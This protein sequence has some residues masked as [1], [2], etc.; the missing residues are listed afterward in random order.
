MAKA[1][2]D[3][4]S[5][6]IFVT[7]VNP[8]ALS[9][10][11]TILRRLDFNHSVFGRQTAG[12]NVRRQ[13]MKVP[14]N[15]NDRP[16]PDVVV[17]D[18]QIVQ[19]GDKAVLMLKALEGATGQADVTV[20]ARDDQGN[21]FTQTFHVTVQADTFNAPPY[22]TNTP[23]SV[24]TPLNTPVNIPVQVLDIEGNQTTLQAQQ[25]GLEE[26]ILF[27]NTGNET[28]I[29]PPGTTTFSYVGTN[30][31]GG[32]VTTTGAT[33]V[34]SSGTAAYAFG[35]S[36]GQV[37]FTTPITLASFHFVHQAG[38]GPFTATFRDANGTA[39]HT[40]TSNAADDYNDPDNFEVYFQGTPV[41]RIDFTGGHVDNFEFRAQPIQATFQI[42]QV[43]RIITVTPPTGFVGEFAVNV[44]VL[45]VSPVADTVDTT[46]DNQVIRV[47]VIPPG[48]APATAPPEDEDGE[49]GDDALDAVFDEIGAM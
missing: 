5:S 8:S 30:W 1:G 47:R 27:D 7:D 14:T 45:Q 40:V 6:Q 2:D 25:I 33:P 22:F 26:T 13:I 4:N 10:S 24:Q 48:T 21:E 3:T 42:D 35:P 11:V 38:Q 19:K 43:N 39:I 29:T 34:A 12:E 23:S 20:T 31:S 32:T 18:V 37:T 36:G 28:G 15:G 44:R 17:Q 9:T 16:M 41:S 49:F 46:G